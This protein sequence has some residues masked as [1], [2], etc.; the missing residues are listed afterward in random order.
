MT[1]PNLSQYSG[2]EVIQYSK[3]DTV[4]NL[5]NRLINP[6]NSED[7]VLYK[8]MNQEQNIDL[9]IQRI[10]DNYSKNWELS[11][12]REIVISSDENVMSLGL[13]DNSLLIIENL[14][15]KSRLVPSEN[16]RSSK[17]DL[18]DSKET[19]NRNEERW[20]SQELSETNFISDRKK[21]M[22]LKEKGEILQNKESNFNDENNNDDSDWEICETENDV[23]F[24]IYRFPQVILY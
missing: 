11:I 23:N 8:I 2:W 7:Y 3:Y 14:E 15:L 22:L 17:N 5:Y 9:L 19:Q 4:K 16:A 20:D 18:L 21:E 24:E 10:K 13:D 6:E 12:D 1:T